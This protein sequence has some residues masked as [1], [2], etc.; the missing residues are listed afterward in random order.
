MRISGY[1]Q[2]ELV[3][4]HY[5]ALI[6]PDMRDAAVNF[7]GR[8]FVK[9][10]AN[11]YYEFPVITKDGRELWIGQNT[12]L[13]LEKDQI[14]GFQAVARDITERR[15]L[16]E[17]MRQTEARFKMITD[18]MNDTIWLMDL[19]YKLTWMS[20]SVERKRGYSLEEINALPLEKH[21]TPAS[22]DI[23]LKTLSKGLD[24]EIFQRKDLDLSRTLE[25]EYFRKNGSMYWSEVRFSLLRDWE[26]V[27][28][29]ILGVG[30]DI[31]ERKQVE[32]ALKESEQR[33]QR[34]IQGSPIPTFVIGRDHRVIYWNTALEELSGIK[35]EELIGTTQQ[36]RAFYGE[37]RPCMSDLLVDQVPEAIP[38]WFFE[39]YIKS[40]LIE[41]A[42]EATD[43]FPALGDVGKWLRFT[44]ALI[45]DTQG[46]SVGAIETLQDVTERIQARDT[47]EKLVQIR[48][49]DLSVKNAQLINEIKVRKQAE[50]E[51]KKRKREI[52]TKSRKLEEL[53]TTLKTL[54]KHREEDKKETE[55]Y[56]MS[57]V[58]ALLIPAIEKLKTR[59]LDAKS[60]FYVSMLESN[61]LDIISPFSYKLSS[62]YIYM[63]SKEIQVANLV[64]EGKSTKEI[65]ELMDVSS[66]AIELH[67]FHIR[68]KLGLKTRKIN[69]RSYLLSIS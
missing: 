30:R 22:L 68:K 46:K 40:D 19:N 15:L 69:L 14:V 20:P 38:Q 43:F 1:S 11:T 66:Y 18:N 32:E 4:K 6:K 49:A 31:T 12:Q 44:G 45:R 29:C 24:P 16:E 34:I 47:L 10:L 33:L 61:L 39:K 63:T 54:L 8:Q 3:G 60:M 41:D 42:Y 59:R 52:E 21:V 58:K 56:I 13:L 64:K 57:N 5:A 35:A 50:A 62:K 17:C 25:L 53:I 36:W 67:R 55:G 37:E 2:E 23:A 65:A 51:L 26:G 7:F 27:P 48:T 9:R 28:V